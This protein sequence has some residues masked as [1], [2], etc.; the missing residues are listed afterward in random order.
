MLYFVPLQHPSLW[1]YRATINFF[2]CDRCAVVLH[3]CQALFLTNEELYIF[4]LLNRKEKL[5]KKEICQLLKKIIFFLSLWR[6]FIAYKIKGLLYAGDLAARQS[7]Q[8]RGGRRAPGG[9]I[10][11]RGCR[12]SAGAVFVRHHADR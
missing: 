8:R 3:L 10:E 4:S 7:G 9:A 5:K 1:L 11:L 6:N 12:E 2:L